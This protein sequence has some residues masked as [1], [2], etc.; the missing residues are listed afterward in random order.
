MS[1][2]E[3]AARIVR[4]VVATKSYM[5]WKSGSFREAA[6]FFKLT[7]K[8]QDRAFND[9]EVTALI[10][11]LFFLKERAVKRKSES[12][13]FLDIAEYLEGAFLEL[14]AEARVNARQLMQWKKLIAKREAEYRLSV[15][16]ALRESAEWGIFGAGDGDVREAWGRILALSLGVLKY[17]RG[18]GKAS[19]KDPL[20]PVL[21]RWLVS[22][23]AELNQLFKET[24]LADVKVLN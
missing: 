16:Y 23:E 15:D 10:Y 5:L 12:I 21:R 6:S 19:V 20:W 11:A 3:F 22:L 18:N 7:N 8:A 17:I 14:M 9:L 1:T 13:V 2:R 24:D 4:D